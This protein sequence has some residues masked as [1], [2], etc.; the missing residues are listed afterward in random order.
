VKPRVVKLTSPPFDGKT[1]FT[2]GYAQFGKDL[3]KANVQVIVFT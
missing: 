2:G 3:E 1:Q